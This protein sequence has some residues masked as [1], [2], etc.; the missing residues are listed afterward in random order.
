M[1][2]IS[3]PSPAVV[4]GA[5]Q[6]SASMAAGVRAHDNAAHAVMWTQRRDAQ[7][8]CGLLDMHTTAHRS[9][10][11][12]HAASSQQYILRAR[13]RVQACHSSKLSDAIGTR[14]ECRPLF[15]HALG[16]QLNIAARALM[17]A[18]GHG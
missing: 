13:A 14:H 12:Q 15:A 16:S 10:A 9:L 5:R 3:S 6:S 11:R 4:A 8:V 1:L 17:R 2:L 18:C 7:C